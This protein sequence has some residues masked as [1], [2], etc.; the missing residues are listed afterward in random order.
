MLDQCG[1]NGP[2]T[3]EETEAQMV[4]SFPK[5]TQQVKGKGWICALI[6]E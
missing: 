2:V 1:M 6:Q 3:D 5:V 4:K